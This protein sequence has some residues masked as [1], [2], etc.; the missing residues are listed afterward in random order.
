MRFLPKKVVFNS[1]KY[2]CVTSRVMKFY[3]QVK[4]INP[5]FV[6]W[7]N[8]LMQLTI[9]F[10]SS[11]FFFQNAK[12]QKILKKFKKPRTQKN[13]SAVLYQNLAV[14]IFS[15]R[16][17]FLKVTSNPQSTCVIIDSDCGFHNSFFIKHGLKCKYYMLFWKR[18]W[19]ETKTLIDASTLT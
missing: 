5:D 17:I 6:T 19:K 16:L 18:I 13:S 4:W 15:A 2:I 7:T 10:F 14:L 9:P 1:S 11:L 3:H 8:D 12:Q